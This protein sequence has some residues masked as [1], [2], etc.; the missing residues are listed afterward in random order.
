VS[1]RLIVVTTNYPFTHNGGEV[2][3]VAPEMRRLALE[4]GT[5]TVAPL[6]A[7]GERLPVPEGVE[8][9]TSLAQMLR[10]SRLRA[11]FGAF[12]VAGFWTEIRRALRR[13]GWIGIARVWRWAAMAWVSARWARTA[14][15]AD[16]PCLLYTYWRGGSTVAFA[17]L[18]ARRPMTG[19][20]TRVH[21]YDLYE[22]RFDPPFQ[23]WHPAL[24]QQL[25]LTAA[26]SRHGLDY[27]RAAGVD[28]K[29]LGLY[30]LGTEPLTTPAAASSDGVLRVVSCSSVTSVKRVPLIA[31]ALVALAHQHPGRRFEWTH[32]G[33][34]PELT[35]VHAA[36]RGKPPGLDVHL[37]GHV[38]NESVRG[39]YMRRPVDAFLLLSTSEGLPVSIQE[40]ASA[41]VPVI[42][43]D[44][45]GVR[46]LVGDDNG[47]LLV[48][49]SS[50][51]EIVGAIERV[52]LE[53]DAT[54]R[55]ARRDASRQ[56]WA[57]GFD[58][59]VNH[60]LFAARLHELLGALVPAQTIPERTTRTLNEV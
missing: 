40:A 43:T 3:F 44:V 47:A 42:A 51:A 9:D 35:R 22:E 37:P 36:L 5:L 56:R 7:V 12:V 1:A 46:E 20:V 29:R 10:R 50:V 39:H 32:F 4:F 57:D 27:L 8:V 18:A 45:G 30:R 53:P 24:Y 54:R 13:G 6:H 19:V 41:G 16:V 38:P 33:A 31:Q 28:A 2:M 55:Q 26:I 34:G 60:S 23:P 25:L 15:P 14:L 48:S 49:D 58:A 59:D 11:Y 17:A 21:G 52:L